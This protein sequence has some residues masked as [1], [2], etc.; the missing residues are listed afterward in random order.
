MNDFFH[1][2]QFPHRP[3]SLDF[4]RLMDVVNQ[5]DGASSE[6]GR[7]PDDIAGEVVD[8]EALTYMAIQR[9]IRMEMAT[10]GAVPADKAAAIW[11]D[12]FVAGAKFEQAGGHRDD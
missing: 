8:P 7:E 2:P 10:G 3:Q 12:G 1:D 4:L 6:G 5:L 9:G 11:M